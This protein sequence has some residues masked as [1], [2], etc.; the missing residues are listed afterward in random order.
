MLPCPSLSL[1]IVVLFCPR[2]APMSLNSPADISCPALL[3]LHRSNCAFVNYTSEAHLQHAITIFNGVP[4][5]PLDRRCK[6][7]V[8]RLRMREDDAKSGV[9]AQRGAGLHKAYVAE[10]EARSL[11]M[12]R[13]MGLGVEEQTGTVEG[14]EVEG[15]SSEGSSSSGLFMK[16]FPRVR[17][18]S[19][20]SL[21]GPC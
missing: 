13:E 16:H 1:W 3:F 4:L 10:K 18:T 12:K 2:L 14:E 6:P 5:R 19:V 9:G 11:E 7:L 8:C 15:G 20:A 21:P 17:L